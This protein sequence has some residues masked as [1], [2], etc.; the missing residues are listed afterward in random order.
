MS[1]LP[2]VPISVLDLAPVRSGSDPTE[3]LRL[4]IETARHADALGYRRFWVAEHHGMTGIASSSP[5]VLI[6]AIAAATPRIRV[7]SGGVMLPNHAPLV[8]AE[9][10]GTLAALYPGRIDLGLGRAPGTDPRTTMAVRRGRAVETPNDFPEQLGELSAFLNGN[11]PD[12]H[13]FAK[14]PAVP[15]PTVPVPIWLLGSSLYS[16]EL[17]GLLGLPFAFAHHFSGEHTDLAIKKY[18]HAFRPG[19]L[20]EPHAMVSAQ[21]VVGE[22]DAEAEQLALPAALGFLRLRQ[23]RPGP[24]P[25]A[26]ETAAHDFTPLERQFV[27]ERWHNQAIGSPDTVRAALGDLLATTGADELMITV[28]AYDLEQRRHTLSAVRELFPDPPD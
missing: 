20:D 8:V 3:A 6:A 27:A 13:P 2:A 24:Q 18:H 26:E 10:F 21:V 15:R 22:T 28:S 19:V 25:T 1:S 11:F 12:D 17:A 16:A 23:G 5:P 9:Q 7:G 14:V 4:T